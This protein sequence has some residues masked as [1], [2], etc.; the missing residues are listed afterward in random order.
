[1]NKLLNSV[2]TLPDAGTGPEFRIGTDGR[3]VFANPSA[4][5]ALG[6]THKKILGLRIFDFDE[7]FKES[8][9]PE[10]LKKIT[11]GKLN[12]Y[13]S[14]QR[15]KNGT[16]IPVECSIKM[17]NQDKNEF[18]RISVIN[19]E[20]R[21]NRRNELLNYAVETSYDAFFI[22]NVDGYIEYANKQ[23]CDSLGYTYDELISMNVSEIDVK[24]GNAPD[25]RVSRLNNFKERN[26]L[27]I[28]S[29]HKR[30][31]GTTFPVE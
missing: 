22:T 28:Q 23:A 13:K 30:K 21:E 27:I 15:H 24:V 18:I 17:V 9:W 7:F 10:T 26:D 25:I 16:T 5:Q 11:E 2:F 4:C 6:Y 3:V 14:M 31:D 12:R 29:T 19:E 20:H 1:M 8:E